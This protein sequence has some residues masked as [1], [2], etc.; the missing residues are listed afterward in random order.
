M[1]EKYKIKYVICEKEREGTIE[2]YEND[3]DV[4]IVL[5]IGDIVIK[6]QADNFF[7]ALVEIRRELEKENIKLL[8][9]GCCRNVYPSGMILDMG[10]GRKAYQLTMGEPAKMSSLVDIFEICQ[11][12][13]YAS[14][15]EQYNFFNKWLD[16][17]KVM[18]AIYFYKINEEYG[19][20]SNFSHYGFELNGRWWLTSEHFF[21]AQ[22]F[23]NTKYEE[24]I[25]LLDNPMKA[26]EMG[27]DRKLPL[28]QD[29]EEIKDV[30]MK[31]A[32]LEKFKQKSLKGQ[33]MIIIG[34][35]EKMVPEK[36]C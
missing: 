21:Q 15:D 1:S 33:Q 13:E 30:I 10:S 8:C 17:P 36:I 29:W 19:C 27:R 11:A 9:K 14:V 26:A 5:N 3:D 23:H 32:V 12:E 24:E 22:K 18:M 4:E 25:R 31:E 6:K 28:R 35:V 7:D 20:F 16:S 34:G 2:T